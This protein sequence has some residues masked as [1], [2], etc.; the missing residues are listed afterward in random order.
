[1]GGWR[2]ERKRKRKRKR[3]R[4][5]ERAFAGSVPT[6]LYTHGVSALAEAIGEGSS[7][8]FI[9]RLVALCT[10]GEVAKSPGLAASDRASVVHLEAKETAGSRT[11]VVDCIV[12]GY[13]R[14]CV[15]EG[16][17]LRCGNE[18]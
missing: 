3:K 7:L 2:R 11:V 18:N 17:I 9:E 6:N 5:R 13:V 12:C 4:E 10:N 1:M 14:V 8:V 15:C 16:G